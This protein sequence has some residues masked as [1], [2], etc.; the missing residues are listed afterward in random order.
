MSKSKSS[1]LDS[2]DD[3]T[4][5]Y[6]EAALW[7]SK[8]VDGDGNEIEPM[9]RNHDS[10]DIA[11]NSLKRMISDCRE[12]QTE[13]IVELSQAETMGEGPSQAGHDFWLTRNH[14][15]A[16][17][18]DRGLGDIGKALTKAAHEYGEADLHLFRGKI[19]LE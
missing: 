7:S 3:F 8:I 17:Y 18:W 13:N 1:L 5:G 9:D 14:H 11:V 4:R 6:I 12:F 15:G 10:E 2:L 19:W 16:G